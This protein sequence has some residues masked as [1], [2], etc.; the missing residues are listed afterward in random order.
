M[1]SSENYFGFEQIEA[2]SSVEATFIFE[3][4]S[5]ELEEYLLEKSIYGDSID[6]AFD[7]LESLTNRLQEDFD[8]IIG[9]DAEKKRF[10]RALRRIFTLLLNAKFD[11]AEKIKRILEIAVETTLKISQGQK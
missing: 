9:Q 2:D 5:K 8:E 10:V 1:T 6:G 3:E 7:F 4:I 11:T